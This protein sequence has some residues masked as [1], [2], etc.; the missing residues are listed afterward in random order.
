MA[1]S[2]DNDPLHAFAVPVLFASS[3]G[4]S[5]AADWKTADGANR[6]AAAVTSLLAAAGPWAG[7][8]LLGVVGAIGVVYLVRRVNVRRVWPIVVLGV[9]ADWLLTG[10]FLLPLQQ[11]VVLNP[12]G[13]W[14]YFLGSFATFA[15]GM[16]MG[17][18]ASRAPLTF[19]CGIVSVDLLVAGLAGVVNPQALTLRL[20]SRI[21]VAFSAAGFGALVG[22]NIAI[23]LVRDREH[24]GR[25][26]AMTV[27][28]IAIAG[29]GG[30]A[31]IA[32]LEYSRAWS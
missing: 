11:Y 5:T 8:V 10:L 15:S 14:P 9:L 25:F 32:L 30:A 18:L 13:P 16:L 31:T 22:R 23:S 4:S 17:V 28:Q 1:D 7:S 6:S 2:K 24:V 27:A 29:I 3:C 20:I 12:L 26:V 21:V 19:G